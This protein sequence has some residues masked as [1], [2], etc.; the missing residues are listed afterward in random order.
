MK[1]FLLEIITPEKIA[2]A[3]QVKMVTVPAADGQLGI[4]AGHVP[5]FTN[6]AEGEVKVIGENEEF[7]LAI[8][9]GY[10]EVA[11]NKTVILV[12]SAYN[13]DEINEQEV[14]EAKKRAEEALTAGGEDKNLLEA[15]ATFRRATLALKV[16]HRKRS[17]RPLNQ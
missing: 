16:L 11:K 10:L 9:S 15:Q 4:L 7:F 1:T 8:G 5:L 3:N 2:F 14:I 12:T 13:A 6:L 17:A